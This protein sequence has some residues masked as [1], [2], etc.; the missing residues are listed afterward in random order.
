MVFAGAHIDGNPELRL[1]LT[2]DDRRCASVNSRES[3][4]LRKLRIGCGFGIGT[5]NPGVDLSS[6]L[7]QLF[8]ADDNVIEL[9]RSTNRK[10][11][12]GHVAASVDSVM[13]QCQAFS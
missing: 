13:A 11:D 7:Q 8:E 6:A 1:R 9:R 2:S 4:R 12:T 3:R 10:E 5:R